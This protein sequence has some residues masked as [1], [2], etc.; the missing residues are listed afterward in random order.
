MAHTSTTIG[1]KEEQGRHTQGAAIVGACTSFC[2]AVAYLQAKVANDAASGVR[3]F[4]A[5]TYLAAVF[6]GAGIRGPGPYRFTRNPMHLGLTL[7][8]CGMGLTTEA[9]WVTALAFVAAVI[10][11]R[12]VIDK[13]EPHLARKF[14]SGHQAYTERVRR[15]Q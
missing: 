14:A 8:G 6:I 2:M 3:V 10:T 5:A 7:L 1:A 4:L 9:L 12:I 15:W 11:K 13:E